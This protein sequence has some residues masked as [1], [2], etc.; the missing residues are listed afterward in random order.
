MILEEILKS[1]DILFD[2][3]LSDTAKNVEW[4]RIA[5][6]ANKKF[7]L[8][9]DVKYYKGSFWYNCR[10]SLGVRLKCKIFNKSFNHVLKF[11]RKVMGRKNLPLTRAHLLTMEILGQNSVKALHNNVTDKD[12]D[13]EDVEMESQSSGDEA[14]SPSK[15]K[16]EEDK[17]NSSPRV[18]RDTGKGKH[19]WDLKTN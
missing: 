13:K 15:M 12:E 4:K 17:E 9:R 1:K 16:D 18:K 5:D 19:G 6:F 11:Q 8:Q 7:K 14:S 3:N 10:S 2:E